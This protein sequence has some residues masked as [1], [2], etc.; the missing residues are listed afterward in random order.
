VNDVDIKTVEARSARSI[1]VVGR[2]VGGEFSLLTARVDQLVVGDTPTHRQCVV[3]GV[4]QREMAYL[5]GCDVMVSVVSR[6]SISRHG[7][8]RVIFHVYTAQCIPT[9]WQQCPAFCQLLRNGMM[10]SRKLLS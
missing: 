2:L 1:R 7:R 9:T 4:T 3:A 8:N 5:V 10:M 6:L